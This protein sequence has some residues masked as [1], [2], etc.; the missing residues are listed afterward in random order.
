[1]QYIWN[2][3]GKLFTMLSGTSQFVYG[4]ILPWTDLICPFD[5][6]IKEIPKQY[7]MLEQYG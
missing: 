4:G 7:L 3:K 5:E 2:R 6:P 1:M